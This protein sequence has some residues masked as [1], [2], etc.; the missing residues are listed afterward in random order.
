MPVTTPREDD[1]RDLSSDGQSRRTF[2]S[3]A[4]ALTALGGALASA[5]QAC[6]GSPTSPSNV[7]ALPVVSGMLAGSAV[8]VAID[9]SSPLASVGGAALVNAGGASLLVARTA[10][11][12]FVALSA[13]CTHQTCTIT[14]F[15]NDTYVCPC[16]GSTFDING[17]VTGGPAP[18]NLHP[19][20]TEFSNGILTI[21]A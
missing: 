5:L 2:C 12:T 17:K 10:Q 9:S 15:G 20:A 19:Y 16:H 4:V 14:G 21:T 18:A 1:M 3:R 7:A 11:A 13:I 6:S 8:T